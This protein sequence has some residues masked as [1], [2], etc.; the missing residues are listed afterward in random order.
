MTLLQLDSIVPSKLQGFH[1]IASL[2]RCL[3][4]L[5]TTQGTPQLK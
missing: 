5:G 4:K 2:G 3:L 1:Q